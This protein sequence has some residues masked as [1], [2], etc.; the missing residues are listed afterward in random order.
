MVSGTFQAAVYSLCVVI[1]ATI[2]FGS[3]IDENIETWHDPS[4]TNINVYARLK[5][6]SNKPLNQTL[7]I[8]HEDNIISFKQ[9]NTKVE[10]SYNFNRVF[11]L[12]QNN[13][14]IFNSA[15]RPLID[16]YILQGTDAIFVT[17][18]NSISDGF[19][20]LMLGS[21]CESTQI[22]A[23]P[24]TACTPQNAGI[25]PRVLTELLDAKNDI[26]D[27]VNMLTL[28]A[29]E[30][31]D[32]NHH[33]S[34]SSH[35]QYICD[36]FSKFEN[37][38]YTKN[39]FERAFY[40]RSQKNGFTRKKI[41]YATDID[42]SIQ[43]IV[44]NNTSARDKVENQRLSSVEN[45][46]S[47]RHHY[48]VYF[49]RAY[50]KVESEFYGI[51]NQ[52][53]TLIL[54]D[55]N[56]MTQSFINSQSV[57][58]LVAEIHES[59][60]TFLEHDIRRET[61]ISTLFTVSESFD[62]K[63]QP[64]QQVMT[65]GAFQALLLDEYSH[66]HDLVM[67]KRNIL[68]VNIVSNDFN[69]SQK[70]ECDL[71]E[72][73]QHATT[74]SQTINQVITS[75]QSPPPAPLEDTSVPDQL[76]HPRDE[77]IANFPE[78][79]ANTQ[80]LSLCQQDLFA[81][82]SKH[83]TA[84]QQ[85]HQLE[86]SIKQYTSEHKEQ[87]SL[88][89][90][91][92][93]DLTNKND[94]LHRDLKTVDNEK[95]ALTNEV[96]K[97]ESRNDELEEISRNYTTIV[98]RF[99]Q[100]TND[101]NRL[102]QDIPAMSDKIKEL[103]EENDRLTKLNEKKVFSMKSLQVAKEQAEKQ[104]AASQNKIEH[105][106]KELKDAQ[107]SRD[108]FN[109]KYR[110][111]E[112]N[113]TKLHK[114]KYQ[115]QMKLQNME[116]TEQQLER[117]LSNQKHQ[118]DK[119]KELEKRFSNVDLEKSKLKENV[120]TQLLELNAV[121]KKN[122]EL[123]KRKKQLESD[124]LNAM[125]KYNQQLKLN[126]EMKNIQQGQLET[127]RQQY[128]NMSKKNNN[129]WGGYEIDFAMWQIILA[130]IYVCVSVCYVIIV[131][132]KKNNKSKDSYIYEMNKKDNKNNNG[133][134]NDNNADEIDNE[135]RFMVESL[136]SEKEKQHT[137]AA[138]AVAVAKDNKND[139]NGIITNGLGS[140]G[141]K[142]SVSRLFDGFN[143]DENKPEKEN[144][145][146]RKNNKNGKESQS[147]LKFGPVLHQ[148][149]SS[150]LSSSSHSSVFELCNDEYFDNLLESTVSDEQ[151]N[152]EFELTSKR[153]ENEIRTKEDL[154]EALNPFLISDFMQNVEQNTILVEKK[155]HNGQS[156]KIKPQRVFTIKVKKEWINDIIE[157]FR[158]NQYF[159]KIK[160][161]KAK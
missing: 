19:E 50:N 138:S 16:T 141:S 142:F 150:G 110:D 125:E 71:D 99:E 94:K 58:N 151:F 20:N 75:K 46:E 105:L 72:A 8:N 131:V 31:F 146:K 28:H 156:S 152:G 87:T 62:D 70:L 27:P 78:I 143:N 112:D 69:Q 86:S 67:Q 68:N 14:Y 51:D 26:M 59:L 118:Q 84:D 133:N 43:Q 122:E 83:A 47:P 130:S 38:C 4:Q 102:Q 18:Q 35:Q 24:E 65:S 108:M 10:Y 98:N 135:T 29:M 33:D 30:V 6:L 88:L 40:S 44:G 93:A 126:E 17:F 39:D 45:N 147:Q 49:V 95:D 53:P 5:S 115:L 3:N 92:I 157:C 155:C 149:E 137:T 97:L 114:E 2:V 132:L 159:M 64:Y 34:K 76:A 80:S 104:F 9:P 54:V 48:F 42:E 79:L 127:L 100:V 121:K 101:Y 109:N 113:V 82:Q 111:V 56:N 55:V 134:Y 1:T 129:G 21:G 160:I 106:E 22:H 145:T 23:T 161:A 66:I 7:K 107:Q 61:P 117:L 41:N 154:S 60:Q 81:L 139:D 12:H 85:I 25:I 77:Q 90:S 124:F 52:P 89:E 32:Y 136:I 96:L 120:E 116:Q 73:S 36:V 128:I 119:Y 91:Q 144:E 123:G 74:E 15:V 63:W 13:Q 57:D 140:I 153:F 103:G 158:N 37:T 11:S 148:E